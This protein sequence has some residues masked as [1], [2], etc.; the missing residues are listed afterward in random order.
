MGHDVRVPPPAQQRP[1]RPELLAGLDQGLDASGR[2]RREGDLGRVGPAFSPLV[3]QT[4]WALRAEFGE[5]LHSLYLYGSVPRGTAVEGRSDLDVSVV[6]H[7]RVDD[8]DRARA[9]DLA[10]ALDRSTT[11]VDGIGILVD[12]RAR[13]LAPAER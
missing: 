9:T 1:R 11:A 3:T 8:G 13:L 6:L 4:E 10:A 5:R 7:D 12:P 2:V